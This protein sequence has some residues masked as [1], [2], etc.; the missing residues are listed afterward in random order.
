L[1]LKR[2]LKRRGPRPVRVGDMVYAWDRNQPLSMD[3]S[4]DDGHVIGYVHEVGQDG[5]RV[6]LGDVTT[7]CWRTPVVLIRPFAARVNYYISEWHKK[8]EHDTP[9]MG[10]T[11]EHIVKELKHGPYAGPSIA[12]FALRILG[13]D[14]LAHSGKKFHSIQR[15]SKVEW[16]FGEPD[17]PDYEINF[18]VEKR[19]EPRV[20]RPVT[21]K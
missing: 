15:E 9:T 3:A 20:R 16:R 4:D 6:G 2:Q 14:R 13:E 12:A 7:L 5:I 1:A 17:G 11:T 10:D 19:V 8:I 18:R 21:T